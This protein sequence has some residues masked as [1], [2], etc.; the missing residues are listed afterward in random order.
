MSRYVI[1]LVSVLVVATLGIALLGSI[2][3]AGAVSQQQ[4]RT[5]VTSAPSGSCGP[6]GFARIVNSNGYNTYVG[7]NCWADP[8]CKQ[9]VSANEPADWK[10][11]ST[12]PKGNTSVKTY[13][14]IQ[15]LF[16]NWC[17]DHWGTNRACAN[18]SDTP[19]RALSRLTFGYRLTMPRDDSGTIAQAAYDIWTS[20]PKHNEVM[21]WVDN[22]NRQ[23][24]GARFIASFTTRDRKHWSLYFYGSEV[25]WSLG[26]RGTFAQRPSMAHVPVH[27]LMKY[28]VDHGYEQ[29]HARVGQID[30]GWEICSSGGSPKTFVVRDYSITAR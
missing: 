5:C 18:P 15:Q 7:N 28:L 10:V 17:G 27:Q 3:M 22:D 26:K 23:S 29:A 20:D 14:D 4:S 30:F 24:G 12:E 1:G 25:I 13:P 19:I 2:D 21:I 6:Y 11:V 16:N 9:T 8:G